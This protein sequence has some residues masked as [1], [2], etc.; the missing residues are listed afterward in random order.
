MKQLAKRHRYRFP[1]LA[2]AITVLVLSGAWGYVARGTHSLQGA[3]SQLGTVFLTEAARF[4][5]A[6]EW[7]TALG[8]YERALAGTLTG[9]QDRVQAH[10]RS[11]VI[12]WKQGNYAAALPHLRVAQESP[13]RSLNGYRPLVESL[14]AEREFTE[15]ERV[16]ARWHDE[17]S[18]NDAQTADAYHARGRLAH[19]RDDRTAAI[20][21]FEAA[22][23]RVPTHRAHIDM[24]RIHLDQGAPEKAHD[25]L[26]TFLSRATPGSDANEARGLLKES[27]PK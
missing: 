15:A 14:I 8:Y 7:E 1:A 13:L 5:A 10:K 19:Y 25:L 22:I 3:T 26:I 11:G 23:Q 2:A 12:R 17:A 24:A 16:V 6:G 20:A 9:E 18:G 27:G 4:E 21:H